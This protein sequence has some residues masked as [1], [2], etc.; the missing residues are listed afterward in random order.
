MKKLLL[1]TV[2]ICGCEHT[3]NV[4]VESETQT[5]AG[6]VKS[7]AEYCVTKRNK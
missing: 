5:P 6:L 4:Y 7:R 3:A 2:L 1:L